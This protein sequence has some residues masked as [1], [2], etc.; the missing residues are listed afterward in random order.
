[1]SSSSRHNAYNSGSRAQEISVLADE[2]REDR[3]KSVMP[4]SVMLGIATDYES[5][6]LIHRKE[7][8]P[9]SETLIRR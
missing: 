2:T 5:L 8:T 6:A 1:M 3:P 9:V 4:K 7:F